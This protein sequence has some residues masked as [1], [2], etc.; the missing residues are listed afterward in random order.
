MWV[1]GGLSQ[2]QQLLVK[3]PIHL[4]FVATT[5][6]VRSGVANIKMK[7][8]QTVR[9]LLCENVCRFSF[10]KSYRYLERTTDASPTK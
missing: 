3:T 9:R 10:F 6:I 8:D 7:Y 2:R 4:Y 1:G 5:V